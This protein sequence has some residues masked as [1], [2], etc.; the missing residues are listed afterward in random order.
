MF[1]MIYKEK[2]LIWAKP[3]IWGET[4]IWGWGSSETKHRLYIFCIEQ[5]L[6]SL[7]ACVP[8]IFFFLTVF[9]VCLLKVLTWWARGTK[10]KKEYFTLME[11]FKKVCW[12]WRSHLTFMWQNSFPD[13]RINLLSLFDGQDMWFGARNQHCGT[14]GRLLS[15]WATKEQG[16]TWSSH[17]KTW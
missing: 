2:K 7:A 15:Q 6:T 16:G 4:K 11:E 1:S 9:L 14:N 10:Q 17:V 12:I 5:L 3:K 13:V 8:E